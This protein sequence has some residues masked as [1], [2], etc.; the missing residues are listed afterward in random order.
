ME[1]IAMANLTSEL[2]YR[3]SVSTY[4][5]ISETITRGRRSEVG[6]KDDDMY[7]YDAH[8]CKQTHTSCLIVKGYWQQTHWSHQQCICSST[9]LQHDSSTATL[10]SHSPDA[11]SQVKKQQ[12]TFAS[13]QSWINRV[14]VIWLL[15]T[16]GLSCLFLWAGGNRN[17]LRRQ[18]KNDAQSPCVHLENRDGEDKDPGDEAGQDVNDSQRRISQQQPHVGGETMLLTEHKVRISCSWFLSKR[19]HDGDGVFTV[20]ILP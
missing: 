2:A 14:H 9:S 1:L 20:S 4:P 10:W 6:V 12:K 8:W 18:K 17:N 19:N 13:N 5:I 7:S 16:N 15:N 3:F 11:M